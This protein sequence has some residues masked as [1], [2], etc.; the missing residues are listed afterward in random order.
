MV[1][2]VE[3]DHMGVTAGAFDL[4]AQV[5]ELFDPAAGQHD[6]SAGARQGARELRAQA[7]GGAG[8]EGRRGP[9]RS[10]CKPLGFSV[11]MKERSF[12]YRAQPGRRIK[13]R[14]GDPH[15]APAQFPIHYPRPS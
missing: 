10:C 8:H 3:L 7:A 5:L 12:D 14:R 13:S 6:G 4:R 11:F 15:S 1:G 9:E 2:H